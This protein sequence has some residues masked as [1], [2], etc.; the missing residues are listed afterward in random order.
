[1]NIHDGNMHHLTMV[2]RMQAKA[3]T[4][5]FNRIF[6]TVFILA[7]PVNANALNPDIVK[8]YHDSNGWKLQ[9]NGNDYYIKGVVWGYSPRGEN[10]TYNLWGETD[11]HIRNVLDHDFTLMKKANINSIRA[12]STIPPKWVSYIYK[13]YGIMT[14]LNPLMGRYGATIGGTWKP[15]TDYS[16]PLTRANLKADLL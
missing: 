12:F 4:K 2:V 7:L 9:V 16:D 8:T 13:E 1:M 6:L 15:V 3:I 5:L 14:A 10:Y 11:E